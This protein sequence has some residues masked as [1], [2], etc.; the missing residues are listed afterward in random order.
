MWKEINTRDFA[1]SATPGDASLG[2]P[3]CLGELWATDPTPVLLCLSWTVPEGHFNSSVLQFKDR[4]GPLVV[5]LKDHQCLVAVI[6]LE[7]G[8]KY[9]FL[10]YNLLGPNHHSPLS[11]DSTTSEGHRRADTAQEVPGGRWLASS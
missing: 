9:R 11:T 5:A 6:P 4:D 7:S 1:L 8:R 2:A 3:P 10:L